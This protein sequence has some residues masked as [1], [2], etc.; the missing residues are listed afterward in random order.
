MADRGLSRFLLFTAP[1]RGE[2]KHFVASFR[3]IEEGIAQGEHA[4]SASTVYWQVVDKISN[5]IV[6]ED[7]DH[8]VGNDK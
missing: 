1:A 3:T 8:L 7:M 5:Q 6:A 4:K 2:R